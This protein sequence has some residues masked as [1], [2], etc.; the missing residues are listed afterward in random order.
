MS[1]G[2]LSGLKIDKFTG[3]NDFS[4]WQMKMKSL[5][6]KG[7]VLQ[8]CFEPTKIAS[9][10]KDEEKEEMEERAIT[11]LHLF[12]ADDILRKVKTAKIA[13]EVWNTLD[14]LYASKS[15][16]SRL[17]TLRSLLMLRM[18]PNGQ[19]ND[20]LDTFSK[21]VSDLADMGL[22]LADEMLA[23]LLLC[24]LTDEY[25]MLTKSLMCGT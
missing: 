24:T 22:T 12:L 23:V 11:T 7:Q 13:L 3:R 5:H 19:V 25:S 18:K 2:S 16:S 8:D 20:H 9:T 21:L 10:V 17:F 6:E 14:T 1:G 4:L 15:I